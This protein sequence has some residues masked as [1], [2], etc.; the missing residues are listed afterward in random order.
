MKNSVA[1]PRSLGPQGS[2]IVWGL[3]CEMLPFQLKY[4]SV[5]GD[6]YSSGAKGLF[7][8]SFSPGKHA[9]KSKIP[10][11]K[12]VKT[13]HFPLVYFQCE[14][15]LLCLTNLCNEIKILTQKPLKLCSYQDVTVPHSPMF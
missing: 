5:C 1:L 12:E 7:F 10:R 15:S 13:E 11:D 9:N 4:I 6:L 8:T 3:H 2:V 14:G